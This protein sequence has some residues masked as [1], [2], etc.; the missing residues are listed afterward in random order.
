MTGPWLQTSSLQT[1]SRP[2]A[3]ND[4]LQDRACRGKRRQSEDRHI[5]LQSSTKKNKNSWRFVCFGY[6]NVCG[7]EFSL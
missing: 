7:F 6:K 2:V 5:R 4:C 1:R 3:G